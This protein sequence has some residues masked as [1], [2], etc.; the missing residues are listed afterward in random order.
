[1]SGCKRSAL[2]KAFVGTEVTGK[3]WHLQKDRELPFQNLCETYHDGGTQGCARDSVTVLGLLSEFGAFG[4]Y[5]I[6]VF[7]SHFSATGMCHRS[8]PVPDP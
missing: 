3:G 1:M 6:L 8:S 7:L 5:V 4:M 2:V